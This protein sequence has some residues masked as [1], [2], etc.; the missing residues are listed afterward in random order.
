MCALATFGI[1]ASV[2]APEPLAAGIGTGPVSWSI[3]GNIGNCGS[4]K[5]AGPDIVFSS[6]EEAIE[7][8][9]KVLNSNGCG[10]G[11][12]IYPAD[13]WGGWVGFADYSGAVLVGPLCSAGDPQ[14]LL[15]RETGICEF[16]NTLSY[17]KSAGC[18]TGG[19]SCVRANPINLG[20]QNKLV[21]AIDYVGAGPFPLRLTRAYNSRVTRVGTLGAKWV[22]GYERWLVSL[23]HTPNVVS[24]Y[25]PDGRALTFRSADGRNYAGDADTPDRVVATRDAG[26][27][28]TGWE[29]SIATGDET[30]RYNARGRLIALAN[31]QGLT[32]TFAY[33][34]GSAAPPNGATAEGGAAA[35]PAG[36]LLSATDPF[37]RSVRFF[38]DASYRVARIVLP[39]GGEIRYGYDATG[40]PAGLLTTV[41]YQDARTLRYVY[42]EPALTTN[43][44]KPTLLTGVIDENGERFADYGYDEYNRANLSAHRAN[45]ERVLVY[46][47]VNNTGYQGG[48]VVE[49]D[50]LGSSRTVQIAALNGVAVTPTISGAA[51]PSCGPA[52]RSFDGNGFLAS[53]TN[54]NGVPTTFARTDPG[55]RKDLETRRVEASGTAQARTI[56]TDW[57]ATFRLPARVAEPLRITTDSYD[58]NGNLL[59][60]SVQATSDATGAAG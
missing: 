55:G 3:G 20:I 2:I 47:Y 30:E 15:N 40:E 34:D 25:R 52:N 54:W 31:R 21:Q 19:Q 26:G 49:S 7:F 33:S 42:D 38:Y 41:I 58:A 27:V 24:L 46:S 22:H 9:R 43:R 50:P 8:A 44:V 4:L 18:P 29:V 13:P 53:E 59:A 32:Q 39:D 11:A 48:N 51:C 56:S 45:G 16:S 23:A 1:L 17:D 36:L 10:A 35:L 5:I 37:G 60:R 14:V 57:H 6:K 12:P 28:V